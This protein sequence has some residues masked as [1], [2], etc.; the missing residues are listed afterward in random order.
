MTIPKARRG[1]SANYTCHA[2]NK[3]GTDAV[4]YLLDVL[5]KSPRCEGRYFILSGS[6]FPKNKKIIHMFSWLK[7][8]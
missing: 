6:T 5:G 7:S 3:A 4:S 2:A 1:D 8:V